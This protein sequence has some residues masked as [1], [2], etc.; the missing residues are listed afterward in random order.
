LYSSAIA[1]LAT[2]AIADTATTA[3]LFRKILMVVSS[4]L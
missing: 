3:A 4:L 2:M 1:T